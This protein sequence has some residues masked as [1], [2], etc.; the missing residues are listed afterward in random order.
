ME[1]RKLEKCMVGVVFKGGIHEHLLFYSFTVFRKRF[2]RR[3]LRAVGN[4]GWTYGECVT[5]W[6]KLTVVK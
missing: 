1:K 5:D 2:L 6:K 4:G 3:L